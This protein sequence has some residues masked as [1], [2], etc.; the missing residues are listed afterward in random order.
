MAT[1]IAEL[2]AVMDADIRPFEQKLKQAD[3]RVQQTGSG[4]GRVAETALGFLGGGMLGAGLSAAFDS[5]KGSI[6]GTNASLE[7]SNI[8]FSTM[9]GSAEKAGTFLKDLQQFAKTTPFEFPDLVDASKKMLAFGF[10]ADTVRPL[11]TS[12]GDA[13][14]AVGGGKEL[15]GGVTMALGQMQAKGKVA[16]GEMLQLAERGIPSWDMLAK[17]MGVDI[18]TAMKQVEKGLVPAQVMIEAFMEGVGERFPNMMAKQARTFDGAMSTI[19]DAINMTTATAFGPLFNVLS[20][21]AIAMADFLASDEIEAWGQSVAANLQFG[22]DLIRTFVDALDFDAP[23]ADMLTHIGLDESAANMIEDITR[24]VQGLIGLFT[25]TGGD[26]AGFAQWL[27]F[28]AETANTVGAILDSVQTK[29]QSIV[30]TVTEMAGALGA[31]FAGD[32]SFE[33]FIASI[34]TGIDE[35]LVSLGGLAG[36][37]GGVI[38][39]LVA[40]IA[41]QAGPI[42]EAV[43]G[44][45]QAFIGWLTPRIPEILTEAQQ[46]GI[47]LTEWIASNVGEIAAQLLQWGVQFIQWVRPQIPGMLAAL[48]DLLSQMVSWLIGTGVPTLISTLLAW[49]RAFVEWVGPNIGPLLA[50]LGGLLMDVVGWIVGAAVSAITSALV[51]WVTAFTSWV[52]DAVTGVLTR[53]SNFAAEIFQW[54]S[55]TAAALFDRAAAI[56]AQIVAGVVEGVTS[57]AQ[58]AF[59]AIH[60]FGAGLINA[61]QSALGIQSP[62]RVFAEIG[63]QIVEG[64]NVGVQTATP[65]ALATMGET[66]T[67]VI[68]TANRTAQNK[69]SRRLREVGEDMVYGLSAGVYAATPDVVAAVANMVDSAVETGKR[70]MGGMARVAQELGDVLV[71]NVEKAGCESGKKMVQHVDHCARETAKQTAPA[72]AQAVAREHGTAMVKAHE[73]VGRDAGDAL[74]KALGKMTTE[75]LSRELQD[76]A[77]HY[78]RAEYRAYMEELAKQSAYYQKQRTGLMGWDPHRAPI[79]VYNVAQG[80]E[81]I[82]SWSDAFATGVADGFPGAFAARVRVGGGLARVGQEIGAQLGQTIGQAT[83]DAYANH[84]AA[85]GDDIRRRI[86]GLQ[87]ADA[88]SPFGRHGRGQMAPWEADAY[89]YLSNPQAQEAMRK[90]ALAMQ[91]EWARVWEETSRRRVGGLQGIDSFGN[92]AAKQFGA[93]FVHGAAAAAPDIAR[94]TA[95][96]LQDAMRKELIDAGKKSGQEFI[97]EFRK[98]AQQDINKLPPWNLD[99]IGL[100]RGR[101]EFSPFP[102]AN[103]GPRGPVGFEYLNNAVDAL[104]AAA[105]GSFE[106]LPEAFRVYWLW[107][108]SFRPEQL[109]KPLRDL[110]LQWLG[111]R[112][113][114]IGLPANLGFDSPFGADPSFSG[115]QS[116]GQVGRA[117]GGGVFAKPT[118]VIVGDNTSSPEIVSPR[119]M[120]ADTFREVLAERGGGRGRQPITFVVNLDGKQISRYNLADLNRQIAAKH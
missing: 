3:Q 67:S 22:I 17:K 65:A 114:G 99:N 50:E 72:T 103:Q 31:V 96:S 21:G 38:D 44:W 85:R 8:A 105:N 68:D 42:A 77:Y 111:M 35:L 28:D 118:H 1:T 79:P 88:E 70:R 4:I 46:V 120:M 102:N 73:K 9:L 62:S 27:G 15:I 11:L 60:N 13:V 115:G 55:N 37:I 100:P 52:A 95:K 66:I 109:V 71:P 56:G 25:S 26:R 104:L 81:A 80:R 6:V 20:E 101:T 64:L 117:A 98:Q 18:P 29:I 90:R 43:V 23:M 87:G 10:S 108:S 58:A 40:G 48:F 59:N 119:H 19:T 14:A 34:S 2:R 76:G 32:M 94:D 61:A 82:N 93:A 78:A 30:S 89:P 113:A 36:D 33:E 86:G 7:Q 57:R 54:I 92:N 12:V 69:P 106:A 16:S 47:G 45:G 91:E 5:I 75:R 39:G 41:E 49:G 116:G 112:A 84:L 107:L 83:A 110:L 63:E 24:R 97:K 53:L 51:S 74:S